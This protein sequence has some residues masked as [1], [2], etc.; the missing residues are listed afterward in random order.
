[1]ISHMALGSYYAEDLRQA[2][3]QNNSLF[4]QNEKLIFPR[5]SSLV[6]VYIQ[7][8]CSLFWYLRE[9][10]TGDFTI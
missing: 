5:R 1:M 10:A 9:V 8:H 4:V 6:Y 3:G 2:Q 7:V